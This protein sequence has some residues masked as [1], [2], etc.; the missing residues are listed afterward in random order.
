MSKKWGHNN[1]YN[2][3]NEILQKIYGVKIINFRKV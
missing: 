2:Q 3:V 1:T